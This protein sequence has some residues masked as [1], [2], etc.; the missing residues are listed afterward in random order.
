VDQDAENLAVDE[1]F[2]SAFLDALIPGAIRLSL[3]DREKKVQDI[4]IGR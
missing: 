1:W 4:R 2:D 3:A